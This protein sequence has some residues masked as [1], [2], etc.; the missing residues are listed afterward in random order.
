MTKFLSLKT[1]GLG[2]MLALPGLASGAALEIGPLKIGG[3][4]WFDAFVL[5][6]DGND[7]IDLTMGRLDFD[8]DQ[9][10]YLLDAQYRWY[11]GNYSF[12]HH[13]WAGYRFE[14]GTEVQVGVNQVPFGIL[15]Y[16]S[17]S[18]WFTLGYYVGLEDDYDLGVKVIRDYGN[19]NIQAAYYYGPEFLGEGAGNDNLYRYSY[20]LIKGGASRFE[21][22]HQF[23]L[24]VATTLEHGESGSS[25]VGMS[26]QYAGIKSFMPGVDDGDMIA[27]A[28]HSMTSYGNWG[29]NLQLT[30]QD[31]SIDNGAD[32]VYPSFFGFQPPMAKE[33]WIPA[34]SV[35]Y[36]WVPE[37]IDFIDSITFY[38]EISTVMKEGD[39]M[40]DSLLWTT[41]MAVASGGFYV[42]FDILGSNGDSFIT[43]D[44]G[45][46]TAD[47]FDF[48]YNI[49]I[50]YYF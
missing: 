26:L 1:L 49:N 50:G 47:D 7:D 19:W 31:Y 24:R 10:G 14:D 39:G 33:A 45:P 29:V 11:N 25:E 18:Y 34:A 38:E 30:Y 2:A 12:L 28:L 23:N 20:D 6:G 44:T 36:T 4:V 41:G 46:N 42:Y 21:E 35:T 43:G 17:A 15:P 5:E 3:A 9:D 13:A 32:F 22:E 37:N 16:I 27:A 8:I 48:R 40:N